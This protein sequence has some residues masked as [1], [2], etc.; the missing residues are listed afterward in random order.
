[1]RNV[2]N[3]INNTQCEVHIEDQKNTTKK[4]QILRI[5]VITK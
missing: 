4:N 5:N 2:H 3:S 1:M